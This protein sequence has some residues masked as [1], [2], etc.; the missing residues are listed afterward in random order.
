MQNTINALIEL[1]KILQNPKSNE[2][3]HTA[4]TRANNNN[5]WFT[6]DFVLFTLKHWS[7]ILTRENLEYFTKNYSPITGKVKTVG[8]V[9]AGNIPLVG[10]HDLIMVLL[11]GHKALVKLSSKDNIL[12]IT[13]A[14]ILSDIEPKLEKKLCFTEGLF[15]SADAVIA[16]GSNNSAR[17]FNKYF[18]NIPH[19]IRK[20]RNSIAVLDGNETP[21]QLQRLAEDVF[22]YF[23]LGCRN[24][25]KIYVPE[26]FD[27]T[28]VLDEFEGWKHLM[29]H[30]KYMNNYI[31]NKAILLMDLQKHLDND[32]L[33]LQENQGIAS[34]MS[35]LYYEKYSSLESL[36]NNLHIQ[37][38]AI[39]CIV[40]ENIEIPDSIPFGSTQKPSLNSFADGI[41]NMDFLLNL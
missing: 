25:S 30:H 14:D 22:M 12:P 38:D 7:N 4:V 24:I 31:Y 27:I 35:V 29:E 16:T 8:I 39:Q 17:Y 19:I 15:K 13:I 20:N 2:Q 9:M 36:K 28:K 26:T 1:G 32:F 41:D 18:G 33:L 11:S 5:A 21:E 34:P 6:T 37:S 40:T 23:G 3:L 10:M